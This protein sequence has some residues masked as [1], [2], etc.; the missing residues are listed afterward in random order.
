MIDT[1]RWSG[2]NTALDALAASLPIV[3]APGELMRGRQ[4]AAMLRQIGLDDLVVDDSRDIAARAIAV[5]RDPG[6]FRE[7]IARNRNALFDR[8]EP[9]QALARIMSDLAHEG[10]SR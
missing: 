2:G 1:T 7:R 5:A 4:S 10:F 8:S 3:A 6:P 9:M